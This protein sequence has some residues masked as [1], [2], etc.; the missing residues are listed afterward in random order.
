MVD[1]LIERT[2]A[3]ECAENVEKVK[4]AKM[5]LFERGNECVC[6]Y[7]I[8]VALADIALAISIGIGAFFGLFSVVLK[9]D[10]IHV[11]FGTRT[12]TTF[13]KLK[14]RKSQTNRDQKSDL[15]FV[16]RHN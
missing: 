4:I 2:S 13:N 7:K 11:K 5:A 1:K 16:Q 6:S 14:N 12:Q 8:C 9:K 10:I 3:G 15:L